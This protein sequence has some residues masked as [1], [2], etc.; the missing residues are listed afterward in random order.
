MANYFWYSKI[1]IIFDMVL[2]Y[3]KI[4][5]KWKLSQPQGRQ[6]ANSSAWS[7]DDGTISSRK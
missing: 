6:K 1:S 5:N 2:T 7:N 3:P 4:Q